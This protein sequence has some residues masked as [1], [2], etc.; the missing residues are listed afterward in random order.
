MGRHRATSTHATRRAPAERHERPDAQRRRKRGQHLERHER[1]VA[2][3]EAQ[4]VEKPEE[5]R[6]ERIAREVQAR[7][8]EQRAIR[9]AE[10]GGHAARQGLVHKVGDHP[11]VSP[12]GVARLQREDDEELKQKRPHHE[13]PRRGWPVEHAATAPRQTTQRQ[14]NDRVQARVR[15]KPRA[16]RH[17]LRK[18][19]VVGA[20][21]EPHGRETH[22]KHDDAEA[23]RAH[24]KPHAREGRTY[25]ADPA[26][27]SLAT[28][29]PNARLT[30]G[31]ALEIPG[32][33]STTHRRPPSQGP[34][35]SRHGS[36]RWTPCHTTGTGDS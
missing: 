17:A 24:R 28:C 21:H 5:R 14:D 36:P 22:D 13:R 27:A 15:A 4:A 10:Q 25:P 11:R 23:A 3:G 26:E 32:P 9:A 35:P 8:V 18:V 12:V 2:K 34:C 20:D 19:S 30:G 7:V 1:E 29:A 6:L 33:Q 16:N 31:N